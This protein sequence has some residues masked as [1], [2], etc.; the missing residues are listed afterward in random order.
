[1][2]DG[3]EISSPDSLHFGRF[4]SKPQLSSIGW[5]TNEF[6]IGAG[7]SPEGELWL[8]PFGTG[9]SP[10]GELWLFPFGTG[11]SPVGEL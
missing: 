10:V 8:F 5:V 7:S 1:M 2:I 4:I 6:P 9:S 11:S 3:V